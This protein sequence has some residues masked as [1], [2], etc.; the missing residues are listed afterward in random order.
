MRTPNVE[1]L[2]ASGSLFEQAHVQ[3]TQCSPS[4]S[5]IITGRYMHVLGHRTQT[6]LVQPAESNLFA[7]LKAHNYSTLMLGKNDM[8]A[9][10]SFSKSFTYWENA[11]GVQTGANA[12]KFG[13]AGC[14]GGICC[15]RAR[16][17][18]SSRQQG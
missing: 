18:R 3:H 6:H 1:R 13:Q 5:A 12:Y 4:R 8:L 17:V 2:A 14:G 11:I 7:L 10:A 16:R 15:A 9:A